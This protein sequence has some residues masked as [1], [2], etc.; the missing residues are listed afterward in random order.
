M[1]KPKTLFGKRLRE[2]RLS[3]ELSQKGLGIKIGLDASVASA[4]LNQYEVGTHTPNF[5][6]AQK[7]AKALKVATAYFYAEDEV[8]AQIILGVG[9]MSLK[10][11]RRVLSYVSDDKIAR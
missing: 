7:L 2:A 8:M 1:K 10:D 9:G 6:I 4:R 3:T 11:K 5:E